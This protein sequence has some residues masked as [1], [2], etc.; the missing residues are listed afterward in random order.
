MLMIDAM[1][2]DMVQV[3]DN[4]SVT[5]EFY[6]GILLGAVVASFLWDFILNDHKFTKSIKQTFRLWL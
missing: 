1:T 6:L 4:I 3:Q 5:R 2:T